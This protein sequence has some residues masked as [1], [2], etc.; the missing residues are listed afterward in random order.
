MLPV[1]LVRDK[2]FLYS[3]PQG[4][5]NTSLTK[6]STQTSSRHP[7]DG[8]ALYLRG[9]PLYSMTFPHMK[10][11]GRGLIICRGRRPIVTCIVLL[12]AVFFL[13]TTHVHH[14][15]RRIIQSPGHLFWKNDCI[16]ATVGSPK[17]YSNAN[18]APFVVYPPACFKVQVLQETNS[19]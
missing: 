9:R 13:R 12:C 10:M 1:K 19:I 7:E 15:M 5:Q 6:A 17:I 18:C 2:Y 8:S 16:S 3:S 14:E 11:V 4:V